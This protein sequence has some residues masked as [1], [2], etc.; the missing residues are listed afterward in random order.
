M[1]NSGVERFKDAYE[2]F[3]QRGDLSVF[4]EMLAPDVEWRAWND[5]GNCHD[6]EEVMK[7]IRSAIDQGAPIELPEFIETGDRLILHPRRMPPFFPPEAEGLFQLVEMRDG[8]I[9]AMRDFIR[10]SDALTAAST[11]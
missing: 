4:Y 6:R 9:V 8:K 3:T 5:E 2:A 7:V 11:P 1:S 10:R